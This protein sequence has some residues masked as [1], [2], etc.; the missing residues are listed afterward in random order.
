MR[1]LISLKRKDQAVHLVDT[2]GIQLC[3][4][5]LKRAEW[6]LVERSIEGLKICGRCL[7]IRAQLDKLH[8]K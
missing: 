7:A 6:M 5:H 2:N 4:I 3:S 1:V 8:Q